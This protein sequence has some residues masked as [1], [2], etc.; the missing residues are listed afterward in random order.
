MRREYDSLALAPTSP[1]GGLPRDQTRDHPLVNALKIGLMSVWALL[2]TLLW[3]PLFVPL[4]PF[5]TARMVLANAWGRV[6]AAAMLCIIGVRLEVTGQEYLRGPAIFVMNHT[7]FLDILVSLS[8]VPLRTSAIAKQAML[9]SPF[10][11]I[12]WLSGC[13]LVDRS[14]H[15]RALATMASCCRIMRGAK[16]GLMIWPEGKRSLDGRLRPFKKGF[17]HIALGTGLPVVPIIT[18]G[19]NLIIRPGSLGIHPG[20]LRI[21]VLP[22]CSTEDWRRDT[23]DEHI[24]EVRDV[25]LC[26][27]PV[28]QRPLLDPS[29]EERAVVTRASSRWGV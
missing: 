20:L 29:G 19:A 21:T 8:L 5:R 16:V 4:L 2:A 22:P 18:H 27:L 25:M 17:G 11:P 9:L 3:L 23:L 26:R 24:A 14:N 7:S 12:I 1:H 6:N 28:Y 13:F 10:G 15:G